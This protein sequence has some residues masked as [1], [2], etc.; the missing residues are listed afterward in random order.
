MTKEQEE[1][2]DELSDAGMTN[3]LEATNKLIKKYPEL[4]RS[5]AIA[6]LKEWVEKKQTEWMQ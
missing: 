1:Y 6:I 3:A 2:L 4:K 5:Q